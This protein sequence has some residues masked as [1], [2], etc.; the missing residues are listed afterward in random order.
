MKR[1]ISLALLAGLTGAAMAAAAVVLLGGSAGG[2][3]TTTVAAATTSAA[4]TGGSGGSGGSRREVSS[5][6]S[7]SP[8]TATQI[9]QQDSSGVV[10]I[11]VR[12]ASGEDSGTGIVLNDSGLILTNNHV[13]AEAS[14]ITVSPGKSA[15]Q[16]TTAT[17]VGADPNS[18][19]ALIKVD[20]SGLG[21]KPLK[22]AS[23]GT[24]E[25]GDPVYAIGNPYGLDETLTRGIVSALGREI[26]APDG[27]KI[28]GAIQ[29]DAAL[30]PGNSG[31]PLIDAQGEVIGVNSQIASEQTD[32]A[33]S[34]PGST[35]VGFAISS[36]T[37]AQVIKTIESGGARSTTTPQ[38]SAASGRASE[39][40]GE[41][42]EASP[43][44]ESGSTEAGGS[45]D[46]EAGGSRGAEAGAAGG[47]PYSEE[48]AA[49]SEVSGG[50]VVIVP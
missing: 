11:R 7:A 38:A 14:S 43:Y 25:V 27:A 18:D 34:Q 46:T 12:T 20:P 45:R 9:Y 35:G 41:S 3:T 15:S 4:S 29:T 26:A 16:T 32:T 24:V 36:N 42:S 1:L 50:R 2:R 22:L 48:A 49:G 44:S 17:L 23:S 39:G 28:G 37:A 30:N 13:A 19:L 10:A 31:G 33:G 8:L 40:A 47:D 5:S 6:S 21:L